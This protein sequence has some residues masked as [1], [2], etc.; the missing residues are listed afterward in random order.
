MDDRRLGWVANNRRYR[1]REV[2]LGLVVQDLV[3]SGPLA[4][5]DRR[6]RLQ[7]AVARLLPE[8][9]AAHVRVAET[10]QHWLRLE[11]DDPSRLYAL[12]LEWEGVLLRGLRAC[13]WPRLR[14]VR[15]RVG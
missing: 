10:G 15:Y 1:P 13:G 3:V 2:P 12:R 7:Q 8:S 6:A 14:E 4:A 11:V 9:L 5:A